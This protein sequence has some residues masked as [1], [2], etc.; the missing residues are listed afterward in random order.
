MT[1]GACAGHALLPWVHACMLCFWH[2]SSVRLLSLV[3]LRAVRTGVLPGARSRHMMM[4]RKDSVLSFR[5][6]C[7][8]VCSSSVLVMRGE[9]LPPMRD[10]VT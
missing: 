6:C 7:G 4:E 8:T 2:R 5:C 9:K 3:L 1:G 10:G